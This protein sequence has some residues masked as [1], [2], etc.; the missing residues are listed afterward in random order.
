V[1]ALLAVQAV[2]AQTLSV[3]HGKV[4]DVSGA[5]ILG[6]V[7]TVESSEGNKRTTASGEDGSFEITGLPAAS[8]GIGKRPC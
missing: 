1:C 2:T 5:A 3:I 4:A 8:Q 7:I 6:A